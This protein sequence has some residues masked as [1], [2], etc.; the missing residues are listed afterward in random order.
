MYAKQM[1]SV[2]L[3]ETIREIRALAGLRAASLTWLAECEAE[4]EF[5]NELSVLEW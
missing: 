5:R 3:V 1:N 4:L 2:E